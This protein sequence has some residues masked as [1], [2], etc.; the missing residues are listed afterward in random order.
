MVK[1]LFKHE[2]L[3]YARVMSLVYIILLTIAATGRVI[4]FFQSNSVV[5]DIISTVANITYG[6]CLFAALSSSFVFGIIRFYKNLF[7]AE[8]YLSFT[9]PVT[10]TQH[11]VAKSIVALCFSVA[12][13]LVILISGCVIT[14]GDFLAEIIKA[15]EYV[16]QKLYEL[17]SFH[18]SLFVLEAVLLVVIATFSN[19]LL[20][21]MFIAIGQLFKKN[22]VLASVGAYFVYYLLTQVVSTIVLIV[23]SV[24]MPTHLLD[25]IVEFATLHPYATIHI[26][27]CGLLVLAGVFSV[28]YFVVTR[29]IINKKLNLE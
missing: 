20:Y 8:G 1:K 17:A 3:A 27:L 14:A 2:F 26:A 24:W 13:V 21:Y 19:F 15:L 4:Q 6:V 28:I 7:T 29:A 11:L 23:F 5:Y 18:I 10:S 22:R 12:T 16:F 25:R 9:L